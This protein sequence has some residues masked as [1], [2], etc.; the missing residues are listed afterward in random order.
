MGGGAGAGLFGRRGKG[1]LGEE[2]WWRSV[3]KWGSLLSGEEVG[4]WWKQPVAV[5]RRPLNMESQVHNM[6]S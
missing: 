3:E 6:S 2:K 4:Q 1:L 5:D